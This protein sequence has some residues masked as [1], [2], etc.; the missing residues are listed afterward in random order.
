[1]KYLKIT[2]MGLLAM[3]LAACSSD[4]EA[5]TSEELTR[6]VVKT[7]FNISVPPQAGTRMSDAVTQSA[8]T[9]ASFRGMQNVT[10]IP[11][12]T[13]GEI[14]STD[15]RL[16]NNLTL[17]TTGAV[18]AIQTNNTIA[19]LNTNGTNSQYYK[20][21]EVPI[22][23][24]SFLFYGVATDATA[25]S[26]ATTQEVNGALTISGTE[27]N[28][29]AGITADLVPIVTAT[30]TDAMAT[31][32]V[33]YLTDIANAKDATDTN[34]DWSLATNMYNPLRN[35]FL[36]LN[37]TTASPMAG[38][39]A[40][41]QALVQDLYTKLSDA[42]NAT[43]TAIKTAIL[44]KATADTDGKLTFDSSLGDTSNPTACYPSKIYL[45]DGAAVVLWNTTN[46]AFEVVTA[47]QNFGV[48][49]AQLTKYVYPASLYYR[50]NSQISIDDRDTH[51]EDYTAATTTSW[52]RKTSDT[53]Y[54]ANS[55]LGKYPTHQ[56]VVTVNTKSIAME[57]QVQ[58]AVGRF[59]VKLK[60]AAAT[61][62]DGEDASIALG[63]QNFPIT[64]VII[65]GQKQVDFEFKPVASAAEYT[66]YDNQMATTSYLLTS[67]LTDDNLPVVNRTLVLETAEANDAVVKFAVEFQNNSGKAFVGK[68]GIIPNGCKFYLLGELDMSK[69]TNPTVP[70]IFK[71][72]YVTTVI[73]TV[74]DLKNAYNIIPDLRAPKLELGLSV[75]LEWQAGNVFTTEM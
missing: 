59:D 33:D 9:V 11:F 50:A 31:A 5:L 16:G 74:Q 45:P 48:N 40:D 12:A 28:T 58:Y 7:E 71:Q 32:L 63:T 47:A 72:D 34:A 73:A 55:L 68:D 23:T 24:R 26:P 6:G 15:I 41:L 52:D 30:T 20:D 10:M 8:G 69:L 65:G 37:G 25:T 53:E 44:T 57:E 54:D 56:G 46:N 51:A 27:G 42:S 21:V 75:N 1:M 61:L 39:S 49:V 17:I 60:A 22:G 14:A 70:S 4:D 18:P 66:I 36:N 3:A 2:S 38:S 62:V 43:A 67:T 35:A 19:T 64:G 13:N 29:P